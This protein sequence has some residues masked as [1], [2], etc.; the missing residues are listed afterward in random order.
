MWKKKEIERYEEREK[1]TKQKKKREKIER[2]TKK[3]EILHHTI[4]LSHYK[5][6]MLNKN[7]FIK[8]FCLKVKEKSIYLIDVEGQVIL[9]RGTIQTTSEN[10]NTVMRRRSLKIRDQTGAVNI[11][12]WNNKVILNFKIR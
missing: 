8:Y 12:L 5:K 2:E 10:D 3:I 1:K 6:L 11:T 9:D 4:L 7:Y